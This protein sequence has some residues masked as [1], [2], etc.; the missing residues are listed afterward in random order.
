[1]TE[2]PGGSVAARSFLTEPQFLTTTRT[3]R[4]G[5]WST[6]KRSPW[7]WWVGVRGHLTAR[8]N[9]ISAAREKA[10]CDR[11]SCKCIVITKS[12]RQF[13]FWGETV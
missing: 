6:L 12:E 11:L 13:P 10:K 9:R 3:G 2:N 1:M 4:Q 5:V 8:P 7:G